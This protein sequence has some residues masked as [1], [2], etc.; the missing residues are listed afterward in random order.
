MV[1][2]VKAKTDSLVF[3]NARLLPMP[4][5]SELYEVYTLG[6]YCFHIFTEHSLTILFHA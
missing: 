3:L 5:G 1:G 4:T 2:V 6:S